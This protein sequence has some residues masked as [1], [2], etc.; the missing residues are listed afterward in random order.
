MSWKKIIK[1]KMEVEEELEM[2]MSD[3]LPDKIENMDDIGPTIENILMDNVGNYLYFNVDEDA[4]KADYSDNV[5]V[6]VSVYTDDDSE[7][8]TGTFDGSVVFKPT[9]GG[10][11]FVKVTKYGVY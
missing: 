4:N 7:H 10:Y 11:E 3:L 8:Y 6:L 5:Y 2:L 9:K 1:S